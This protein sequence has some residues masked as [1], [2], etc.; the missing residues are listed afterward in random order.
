MTVARPLAET[1][2]ILGDPEMLARLRVWAEPLVGEISDPYLLRL[3]EII[4]DA[5]TNSG[6]TPRYRSTDA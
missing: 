3:Q 6:G 5:A 2:P 1:P 4:E